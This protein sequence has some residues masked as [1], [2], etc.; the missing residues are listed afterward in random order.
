MHKG[1]E[2][3]RIANAPAARR[4]TDWAHVTGVTSQGPAGLPGALVKHLPV[5]QQASVMPLVLQW[6][7]SSK[8]MTR[9][10]FHVVW[11]A[12]FEELVGRGCKASLRSCSGTTFSVQMMPG[13]QA[14]ALR[15]TAACLEPV[16]VLLH[17]NPGTMPHLLPSVKM[18]ARAHMVWQ[19]QL[20]QRVVRKLLEGLRAKEQAGETLQDRPAIGQFVDLHCLKNGPGLAKEGRTSAQ[21]LLDW[22]LHSRFR[23]SSGNV[24]MLFP[25]SRSKVDW[26]RCQTQ[27][28]RKIY[29][30]RVPVQ[31]A[32]NAA[33][34]FAGLATATSSR[35]GRRLPR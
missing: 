12:L 11:R 17:K 1:I 20:S 35:S 2:G 30:P 34:H 28:K 3:A 14:G 25:T 29:K 26:V 27:K 7:R 23:D 31:L 22:G 9:H 4:V 8:T 33:K 32:P 6:V 5:T 10:L 21:E 18:P 16:S 13:T 15:Q 24:W 19:E